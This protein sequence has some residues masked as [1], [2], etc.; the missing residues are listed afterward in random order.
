MP[1]IKWTFKEKE[2]KVRTPLAVLG[3][4]FVLL[5]W[6]V[7]FGAVSF[8]LLYLVL[9]LSSISRSYQVRL[10]LINFLSSSRKTGIPHLPL[11]LLT[12]PQHPFLPPLYFLIRISNS[13][14]LDIINFNSNFTLFR[15]NWIINC[16]YG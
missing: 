8:N 15:F 2:K 11:S 14:L 6:V 13:S 7:I 5:P 16:F 1:E 9:V 4:V 10:N 3:T 12:N